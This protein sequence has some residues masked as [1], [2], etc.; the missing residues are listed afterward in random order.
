[1]Y[2]HSSAHIL[3]EAAEL[4]WGC[5][6]CIG[7]PVERGF[8]YEMSLPNNEAVQQTDWKPLETIVSKA[9]KEK[10]KFERLV[11]SKADLLEVCAPGMFAAVPILTHLQ[12]VQIQQVQATHHLG[13][14]SRRHFYYR[15]PQRAAD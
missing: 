10:Q 11:L 12:D 15:L 13:Q 7:P 8:Y 6:L 4:R 5:S 9:I 14:D 1:M 3:G 2:W